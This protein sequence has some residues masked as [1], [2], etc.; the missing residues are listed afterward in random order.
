MKA[1][2][3][4]AGLGT[5]LKTITSKIP[6]ALVEVNNKPILQMLLLKLKKAGI[7]D[8][9][10]NTY[11]FHE[12]IEAF[13]NEYDYFGLN[14]K[15]SHELELL[16]TG[17]GLINAAKYLKGDEPFLIHNVDVI[18]DINIEEMIKEHNK[19]K[20]L[21]TLAVRERITKRY[22]LFDNKNSLCGW[23]STDGEFKL[24]REDVDEFNTLSFFILYYF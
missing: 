12:K 2:I 19:S 17:G 5:R 21:S 8:I 22:L 23:Y 7:K 24:S 11:H 14:I 3:F 10:I 18:T 16:D 9:V 6:K 20:A 1:M 13:L 4:A 15:I